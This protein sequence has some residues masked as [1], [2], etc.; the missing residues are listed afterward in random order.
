ML[1]KVAVVVAFFGYARLFAHLLPFV[2]LL[3]AVGL[4]AVRAGHRSR[5]IGLVAAIVLAGL[6]TAEL[7]MRAL[8]PTDLVVTGSVDPVTGKIVQDAALRI[9]PR[10]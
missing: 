7:G 4:W 10:L 3:A 9:Q 1:H 5:R 2:L 6:L 8:R